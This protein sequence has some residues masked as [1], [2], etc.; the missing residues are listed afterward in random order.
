ML[1]SANSLWDDRKKQF[2]GF[3]NYFGHDI[4]LDSSGFVAMKLYGGY[5]FT[6]MQYAELARVLNPAWWAQMDFCCEPEIA[7]NREEVGKRIQRTIDGLAECRNA[8]RQAG[9]PEPMPVLQGYEPGDYVDGPIFENPMP[10]LVGIGSV[11]R[12]KLLGPTGLMAVFDR[13]NAAVPEQVTL[14]LFGVKGNA[15]AVIANEFPKR[16]IT[17]DSMAYQC[18]ARWEARKTGKPKDAAMLKRH[19]ET[20]LTRNIVSCDGQMRLL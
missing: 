10:S 3:K 9:I 8:A 13:I 18:G 12:R 2:A 11:C 1:V 4:A 17:S 20:W 5:R 16:K 14:H 19:A 15:L 7:T 6:A